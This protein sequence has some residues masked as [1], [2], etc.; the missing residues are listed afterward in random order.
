MFLPAE[1]VGLILRM[2]HEACEGPPGPWSYFTDLAPGV[3]VLEP[4][5]GLNAT[6][7]SL[8]GGPGASTIAGHAAHLSANL[9]RATS[10]LRGQ[11]IAHDRNR[12]WTVSTVDEE[13][14]VHLQSSLRRAYETFRVTI[15]SQA[16]W[17]EESIG[18]A[19]GAIA[20]PAYHLGAIRQRL[21]LRHAEDAAESTR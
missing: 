19:F 9:A 16:A 13:A 18:V 7:V 17:S 12:T 20:H 4:L 10:A 11:A 14:W 6:Q 1:T 2:L 5:A 15:E 8:A 21:A 3:G